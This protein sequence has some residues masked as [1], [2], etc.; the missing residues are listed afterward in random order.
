MPM[1]F[2]LSFICVCSKC[3]STDSLEFWIICLLMLML[4]LCFWCLAIGPVAI[5]WCAGIMMPALLIA[6]RACF[7]LAFSILYGNNL[8]N[9]PSFLAY[10]V[11]LQSLM[12]LRSILSLMIYIFILVLCF[13]NA[14]QILCVSAECGEVVCLITLPV[15]SWKLYC[16]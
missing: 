4:F 13:L 8:N 10:S 9:H 6:D 14:L 3:V 2:I 11:C 15:C 5:W 16:S 12:V 7:S 1:S